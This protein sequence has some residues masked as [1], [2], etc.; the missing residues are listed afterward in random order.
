MALAQSCDNTAVL[1]LQGEDTCQKLTQLKGFFQPCH[2]LLDPWPFYQSCYLDGCYNHRNAQV[3]GSLAAYAEACRSL[4]TLSTKW[5]TQENCC[6][7]TAKHQP[8][9]HTYSAHLNTSYNTFQRNVSTAECE[10]HV[11][12][13][14]CVTAN[15]VCGPVFSR[16]DLRPLC[17]RDL[18]ELHL[19]AGEWRRL[20][21]LPGVTHQCW[22]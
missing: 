18:H 14:R 21:W 15:I 11:Y 8:T 20:V 3:C 1:A 10:I 4:G 16:M 2:G 12:R 19:R 17:R 9:W 22:K 6:K 7:G 13:A 5:I